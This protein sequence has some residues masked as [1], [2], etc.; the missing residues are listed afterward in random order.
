MTK[1][2]KILLISALF[3]V[4]LIVGLVMIRVKSNPLGL[5]YNKMTGVYMQYPMDLVE[6]DF[7]GKYGGTGV[8]VSR[9]KQTE[10]GLPNYSISLE[11]SGNDQY[12]GSVDDFIKEQVQQNQ[13]FKKEGRDMPDLTI[14]TMNGK[15]WF[16]K[17]HFT[18][19]YCIINFTLP[20][21]NNA[22]ALI[23]YSFA[24][25]GYVLP[26]DCNAYEIVESKLKYVPIAEEI[27]RAIMTMTQTFEIKKED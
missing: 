23:E 17:D 19:P 5:Y 7:S 14:I 21:K 27:S 3:L 6:Q 16:V 2:K 13:I 8:F 11:V 12:S 18:A 1:R 10:N 15:Q 4:I 20:S 9:S 22:G 24:V 25:E 26:S